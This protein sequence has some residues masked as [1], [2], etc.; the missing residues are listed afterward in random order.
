M[1]DT[2]LVLAGMLSVGTPGVTCASRVEL[3][4]DCDA[5]CRAS[6]AGQV[7]SPPEENFHWIRADWP[8]WSRVETELEG[9]ER[10]ATVAEA[11]ARVASRPPPGWRWKRRELAFA[12]VTV[13]RHESSFWR[14]VEEGRLRGPAGE[15]GLWQCHPSLPGCDES[16]VGLDE[17]HVERAARF[18]AEQLTRA[19]RYASEYCSGEWLPATFTLY[20]TGASCIAHLPTLEERLGTYARVAAGKEMPFPGRLALLDRSL[21]RTP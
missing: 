11:V 14:S 5:A 2:A 1:I 12:L 9:M 4:P 20:G 21:S 13:A 3:S 6:V 18:A 15:W 10:W 8:G 17:G 19:R 16:L 7:G